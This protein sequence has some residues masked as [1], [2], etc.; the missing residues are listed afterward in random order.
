[1]KKTKTRL[2]LAQTLNIFAY[3]IIIIATVCLSNYEYFWLEFLFTTSYGL[4]VTA[5]NIFATAA[6]IIGFSF[7]E[8][9]EKQ[10]L[11]KKSWLYIIAVGA[12][13]IITLPTMFS[14]VINL[15]VGFATI[16]AAVMQFIAGFM[17]NNY[18]EK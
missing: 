4:C 9:T 7:S 1:M 14:T 16:I 5:V 17:I 11:Y 3:L 12:E 13:M 6:F 8:K 18:S 2:K 15:Y 10:A